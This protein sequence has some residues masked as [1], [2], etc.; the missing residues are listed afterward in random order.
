M[1][2]F[3]LQCIGIN[4]PRIRELIVC[5]VKIMLTYFITTILLVY[6]SNYES[7]QNSRRSSLDLLDA[8]LLFWSSLLLVN[9]CIGSCSSVPQVSFRYPSGLPVHKIIPLHMI[10]TL[11]YHIVYA[12]VTVLFSFFL[13]I[14]KS[15]VSNCKLEIKLL[16]HAW[17]FT[18]MY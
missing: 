4:L 5:G 12:Y 15:M 2:G 1:C 9:Y 7:M 6:W 14:I 11:R 17:T 3:L 8:I 10:Y 16:H 18:L 13:E